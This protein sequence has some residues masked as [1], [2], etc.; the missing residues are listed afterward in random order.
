[1][2]RRLSDARHQVCRAVEPGRVESRERSA[3][4]RHAYWPA[5]LPVVGGGIDRRASGRL[6]AVAAAKSCGAA[7]D[8]QSASRPVRP[9]GSVP[10]SEFLQLCIR[11]GECFKVC[12]NNVLQAEGFQQGLEG[13]GLRRSLPIGRAAS[14][15]AT[16]VARFVRPARFVPCRWK[17][18]ASRM[19]L[20]I[21][22][23]QTC[24]PYADRE[25]CQLCVTNAMPRVMRRSSSSAS[26]P[27]VDADGQPIEGTG[28][29]RSRVVNADRCVGC[30]LCQTR[31]NGINVKTKECL[32]VRRSS[33]KPAPAK[34]TD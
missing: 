9:P 25:A 15:V 6:A 34:K 18:N 22:N 19:G 8:D 28:Y 23:E 32:T 11:C 4:W 14:R 1:M 3:D 13:F 10:E 2:W 33:S 12:P 7:S 20:A 21:V 30:G 29:P 26:T 24:L 17:R 5:R 31:C 16:P 27:Q